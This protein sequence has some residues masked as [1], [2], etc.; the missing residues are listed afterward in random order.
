MTYTPSF[1]LIILFYSTLVI[2]NLTTKINKIQKQ[3]STK[4]VRVV[5][6]NPFLLKIKCTLPEKLWIWYHLENEKNKPFLG[7]IAD[8]IHV[9]KEKSNFI[10]RKMYI[11]TKNWKRGSWTH[12]SI[13]WFCGDHWEHDNTLFLI[14]KR[15]TWSRD[16]HPSVY[17]NIN[18]GI[19]ISGRFQT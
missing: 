16:T 8:E 12:T 5:R 15:M 6:I 4:A 10:K 1:E 18:G 17:G 3:V 9:I 2:Q 11:V 7:R 13:V 14:S 19:D